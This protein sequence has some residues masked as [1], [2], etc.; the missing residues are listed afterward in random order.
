MTAQLF[1]G[2]MVKNNLESLNGSE[3][4]YRLK[5]LHQVFGYFLYIVTKINVA[6]GMEMY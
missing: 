6:I 3:R 1:F 5:G 2:M 4:V